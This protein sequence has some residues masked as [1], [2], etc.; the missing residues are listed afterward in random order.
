MEYQTVDGCYIGR[1]PAECGAQKAKYCPDGTFVCINDADLAR[2]ENQAGA[3]QGGFGA[4][5][6]TWLLVGI[7]AVL[8]FF[9]LSGGSKSKS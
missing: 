8:L 4:G 9:G 1:A 5:G 7:A 3:P 6:N 2:P